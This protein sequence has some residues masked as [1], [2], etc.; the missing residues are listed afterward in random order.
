MIKHY[1]KSAFRNLTRH[2][3]FSLI[4]IP[5]MAIA[6][7]SVMLLL[8][9]ID[10]ELNYDRFFQNSDRI[11]RVI[12]DYKTKGK[13]MSMPKSIYQIDQQITERVPEVE[14]SGVV[15]RSYYRYVTRQK[16]QYGKYIQSY[17]DADFF[18][19]FSYEV[20]S[21]DPGR[22]EEPHTVVLTRQTAGEI[23]SHQQPLGQTLQI[24]GQDFTVVAVVEDPPAQTHLQFEVL[25]SIHTLG[26][27]LL[28]SRGHDFNT[29]FLL[30]QPWSQTLG[31]KITRVT[32]NIDRER[33]GQS[34]RDFHHFLQPLKRIHLHSDFN[35]DLAVTT[36]I[37]YIYIYSAIAF[38]ILL[39]AL[40]NFIN[41]SVARSE[42][43]TRE[44]GVR[45]VHGASP[46]DLRKQF[47]G[48]SLLF[49]WMAF[50]LSLL[51]VELFVND[52][53]RLVSSNLHL[54]FGQNYWWIGATFFLACLVGIVA[55]AYPAFY[56]SRKPS[57]LV[58]KGHQYRGKQKIG[59]QKILVGLQF[60]IA[61]AL[62]AALVGIWNQIHFIEKKDLGFRQE[63]ILR[64]G[65][66]TG[67]I[68]A[69]Y[70]SIRQELLKSPHVEDV[71]GSLAV[72]GTKGS[73]TH[74]S[75]AVSPKETVQVRANLVRPGFTD[76]YD[77]SIV[78]GRSFSHLHETDQE[79][80]L[81]NQKTADLLGVTDPVGKEVSIW[82]KSGPIL[83]VFAD[84]HNRSLHRPMDPM[85]LGHLGKQNG[86]IYNLSIRLSPTGKTPA[87][88][89]IEKHLK[90]YD[91]AY[92]FQYEF[93]RDYLQRRYY[94]REQ[95]YGRLMVA[96]TL[97]ALI[98]SVMGLFS[99]TAFHIN[100]KIKEIGIRKAMGASSNQ[101]IWMFSRRYVI[102]VG[103]AAVLALPLSLLFI[104]NWYSNFFYH[105]P[106]H[107]WFFGLAFLTTLLVA[108]VTV[109]GRASLAAHAN[110]AET[111]RDE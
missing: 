81:I 103:M 18:R 64:V 109:W 89:Y 90:T 47:T 59:L 104:R 32:E 66:L 111:L 106:I 54:S 34:S 49:T 20:I 12:T 10:H 67:N 107:W 30:N 86:L 92:T 98:L 82:G 71:T 72:P 68:Q 27:K 2:K 11:C 41:L 42:T 108:L 29:Y 48:E 74:L 102:W 51:L 55:G 99:L 6:L 16:K 26:S 79:G 95:K 19:V 1:L 96:G 84:Y 105:S 13:P 53:S 37:E 70:G 3:G 44:V 69:K 62:I 60:F 4:N 28:L 88:K 76:L 14:V 63:N 22:L 97:L 40:F 83:G 87:I 43:R 21:G 25:L 57:M 52:F 36:D 101:I 24:K 46:A 80:F 61:I 38:F 73:G 94:R 31:E 15:Y 45:K 75:L 78:E 8:L 9:F 91:P 5:G 77:I 85:V 100:R 17:A 33:Y 7:A 65:A 110:P 93:L 39:I 50:L 35:S 56:L 23:F 58:L